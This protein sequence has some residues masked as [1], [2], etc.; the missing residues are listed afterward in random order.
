MEN[1]S[2]YK[3]NAVTP[4]FMADE[5]LPVLLDLSIAELSP[6]YFWLGGGRVSLK[7][8]VSVAD[9]QKYLG[10]RLHIHSITN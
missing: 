2:G 9:V 4:F 10:S 3:F 7:T 8:G 6:A 5:S 1:L